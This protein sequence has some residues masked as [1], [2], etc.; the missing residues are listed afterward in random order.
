[1]DKVDKNSKARVADLAD[2]MP[3]DIMFGEYSKLAFKL[4]D[5]PGTGTDLNYPVCGLAGEAGEV[6]DKYAKILRDKNGRITKDDKEKLVKE[7]GDVLWMMNAIA[8]TLGVPLHEV[9]CRN[10]IKLY[11]R[12]DRGK[13]HGEGDER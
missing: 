1:M 13:I 5:Y 8:T 7:L 2:T 9:A 12:L 10:L 11:D 6:A 4:A 3:A